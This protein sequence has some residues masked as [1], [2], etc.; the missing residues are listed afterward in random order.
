M[1]TYALEMMLATLMVACGFVLIL[2]G[3]TFALPHYAVV[4]GWLP[5]FSGGVFL[6]LVGAARW[7]AILRNG[8]SRYT[9]LLRIGG[10]CIGSGFWL[11]KLVAIETAVVSSMPPEVGPPLLLAVAATAFVFE[12]FSAL[13]G[14]ADAHSLDSLGIRQRRSKAGADA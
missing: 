2:P 5:E 3:D 8:R 6:L 9:P 10:C 7:A 11:T 1:N 14:G 4:Q 12:V 13:R